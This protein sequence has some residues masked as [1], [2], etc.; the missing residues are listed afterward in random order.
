VGACRPVLR[1]WEAHG[2]AREKEE[3][4]PWVD[5]AY[6]DVGWEDGGGEWEGEQIVGLAAA[7]IAA[8]SNL[9]L[10]VLVRHFLT[11]ARRD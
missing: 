9:D 11:L 6:C 10:D 3:H 5:V 2:A 7:G 4:L 8:G 1:H